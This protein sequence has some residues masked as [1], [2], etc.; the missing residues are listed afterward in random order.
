MAVMAVVRAV[1]RR[2]SY[3]GGM[4]PIGGGGGG[5]ALLAYRWKRAV[6]AVAVAAES[7]T[8]T[9]AVVWR[10]GIGRGRS[11]SAVVRAVQWLGLRCNYSAGRR[12]Y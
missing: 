8:W 7:A 6:A 5:G 2:L 4:G 12:F 3:G 9:V 11:D 10:A 1:Q